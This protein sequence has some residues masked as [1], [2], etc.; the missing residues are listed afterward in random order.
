[1]DKNYFLL[2]RWLLSQN[3]RVKRGITL[4]FDLMVIE[5]S[6]WAAFSL[7][8]GEA[9]VPTGN[10]YLLFLAAP[11]LS[12]PIYIRLG[13]Y[14]AIIRYMGFHSL[15]VVVKAVSLYALLL[16]FVVLLARIE[17][18]PRSVHM[19]N[20][21]IVLLA[22][23]G[24]RMIARWWLLDVPKKNIVKNLRKVV[25]YGAGSSGV[26]VFDQLRSK[27]D[28]EVVGF[29]DDDLS[30]HHRQ[31]RDIRVRPFSHLSKLIEKSN[32]TDILLAMPSVARSRRNQ[33]ITL[34]EPYP[35]KVKTLPSF[36]EIAKG[37]VRVEDIRDVEIEDLLG[38]DTVAPDEVL[39]GRN[40]TGKVVM[41]TG[42]GGSIGS[43]LCRQ[44]LRLKPC[45]LLLFENNEFGLYSLDE[46]LQQLRETLGYGDESLVLPILGS[47][48]NKK[49]VAAVCKEC[50]VQ[51]LYHAAAYKHVPLVE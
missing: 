50:G 30:M 34:L 22:I 12:I 43:E 45:K 35:V 39:L 20:F 10:V 5:L 18:V 32:V 51:T 29:I 14:R 11:L 25:I 28:M 21:L 36:A 46:E 23:G 6:L 40:I 44:I 33:I 19:I 31:I 41:V 24:S 27:K 37:E 15:W 3:R 8:L 48:F 2:P 42:A 26:Q 4:L 7:R 49:R 38:R 16:S 17:P 13:L 47:V 9:Y 1:M